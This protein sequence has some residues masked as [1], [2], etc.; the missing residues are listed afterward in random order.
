[1]KFQYP[2][3][4]LLIPVVLGIVFFSKKRSKIPGIRFSNVESLARL[5][6]SFKVKLSR[7]IIF[8]RVLSL[9]FIILSL[10]RP[11]SVFEESNILTKGIDIVLAIDVS[12]SM[13]A[14]DFKIG[15]KRNNR[16]EA[17]KDVIKDF[18]GKRNSDKMGLVV[19]AS[20]AYT[21]CPLTL[22]HDWLLLN[23]ERVEI[24]M[25]EDGTAL[26]S[27]LISALNR[28]KGTGA[29]GKVVIFLTDGRNNAGNISPLTAVAAARAL[30][31]KVY[32]I[33]VGSK[34]VALYPAQD[35]FGK[36]IYKPVD[37]AIDEETLSM[38]ASKTGAR[39]FM[40]TDTETLR[41]IYKEID[42]LEKNEIE[43]K[44][45]YEHKELFHLFLLAGLALLFL[46]VILKNTIL[47]TIP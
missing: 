3:L 32:T 21:I 23:L 44:I 38:M 1:M 9:L 35:L 22:D 14:E 39:Y 4:L 10:A 11:Q 19:F 6:E 42:R 41:E 37:V 36:T 26:G 27:G 7:N 12:T 13:L 24:G 30:K 40:A 16:L 17:A 46:E 18:V 47:R 45:Y 33:G 43:E 31:V 15:T 28:L 25:V 20:R 34:G 8:L 5:K 2:W 29:K